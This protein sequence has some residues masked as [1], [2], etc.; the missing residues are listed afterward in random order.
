MVYSIR[1]TMHSKEGYIYTHTYVYIYIY[2]DRTF[3]RVETRCYIVFGVCHMVG[4]EG[5][6]GMWFGE[7]T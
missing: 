1:I 6:W 3:C 2:I 4:A 7:Y 5:I